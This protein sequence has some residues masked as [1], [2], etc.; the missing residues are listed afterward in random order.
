MLTTV[1]LWEPWNLMVHFL[2][3]SL[4]FCGSTTVTNSMFLTYPFPETNE[5][6]TNHEQTI[7]LLK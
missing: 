1:K 5:L 7:F 2:K 3:S 6:T 4:L